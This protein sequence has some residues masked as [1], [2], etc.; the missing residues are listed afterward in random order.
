MDTEV[1]F[2]N[3]RRVSQ[4]FLLEHELVIFLRESIG[5]ALSLM[6]FLLIHIIKII[7]SKLITTY[8]LRFA[9]PSRSS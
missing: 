2:L 7:K 4:T 5:S 8:G 1:P 9:F 3:I 6:N